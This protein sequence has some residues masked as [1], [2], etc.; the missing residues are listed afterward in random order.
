[1]KSASGISTWMNGKW[2]RRLISLR[3]GKKRS[4]R[5]SKSSHPIPWEDALIAQG[6][7]RLIAEVERDEHAS[8][9]FDDMLGK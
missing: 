2:S 8:D 6:K 5:G 9:L 1:M 4:C 7:E 3:N